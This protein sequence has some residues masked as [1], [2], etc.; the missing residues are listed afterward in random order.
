MQWQRTPAPSTKTR[1]GQLCRRY[2]QSYRFPMTEGGAWPDGLRLSC[3]KSSVAGVKSPTPSLLTT[4]AQACANQLSNEAGETARMNVDLIHRPAKVS[5]G[6]Q[7]ASITLSWLH[8]HACNWWER[9]HDL[10]SL[11][12]T[13]RHSCNVKTLEELPQFLQSLARIPR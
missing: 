2:A 5:S 1:S 3:Q 4:S 11:L 13:L 10:P 12:S 6:L 7:P 9:P 8:T